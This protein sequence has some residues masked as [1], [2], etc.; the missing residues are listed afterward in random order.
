MVSITPLSGTNY[1]TFYIVLNLHLL[2]ILQKPQLIPVKEKDDDD[3]F[4]DDPLVVGVS[5]TK[6]I[7]D[8]SVTNKP[9]KKPVDDLFGDEEKEPLSLSQ[10]I[11]KA[12]P[13]TQKKTS[14]GLF[15]DE[16][17]RDDLFTSLRTTERKEEEKEEKLKT[18][19]KPQ[20]KKP[21]GAVPMFGGGSNPF[22]LAAAAAAEKRKEKHKGRCK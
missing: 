18:S 10:P 8:K 3:L 21:A 6:P 16:D 17:E 12:S 7:V 11:T 9:I 13:G 2:I 20:K 4:V 5:H 14:S 19:P 15:S 1:Y 22:N